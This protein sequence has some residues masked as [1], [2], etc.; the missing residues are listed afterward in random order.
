MYHWRRELERRDRVRAAGSAG[1]LTFLPVAV[2]GASEPGGVG[3][4]GALEIVH[5]TGR[6]IRVGDD[7]DSAVLAKLVVLLESLPC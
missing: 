1:E 3:G 5:S 4:D 6:R 7:F 2:H